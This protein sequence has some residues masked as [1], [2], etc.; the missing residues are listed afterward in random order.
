MSEQKQAVAIFGATGSIGASTLSVLEQHKEK[1][2]LYAV[3]AHTNVS[4]MYAICVKFAPQIAVMVDEK[5]AHEL[6]NLLQ[7]NNLKTNVLSGSDELNAVAGATEV[8]IVVAAI[9]GVA[10]LS[11]CFAAANTGK[12]ILLAN[13]ESIVVAGQFLLA[14]AEKNNAK[15]IPLDSE[16]NAIF[17]CHPLALS[18]V[19]PLSKLGNSPDSVSKVFLTASGGPFLK[20]DLESFDAITP[21]EA[22]AHPRWQMGKKISV[23]SATMMNKGLEF[24]EA[25]VRFGLAPSQIEVVIHPQSIVHSMV[26]YIDGSVLAQ[27]GSADMRIPIAHALGFPDRIS[28]GANRLT[29]KKMQQLEFFEPC[30]KRFPALELAQVAAADASALPV[31]LNAANEISVAAFLNNE[32]GFN[33]I[34]SNVKAQMDRFKNAKIESLDDVKQLDNEVRIATQQLVH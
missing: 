7:E 29:V 4:E 9:V 11:S 20:R 13:K 3:T 34:A 15:I 14:A 32:I 25:S 2:S 16:H 18:T 31:V 10:G 5:S 6:A 27:L 33:A 8:D 22:C 21:A 28:S 19:E 26:E 23:D 12:K 1:F 24:I 17:Q 30:F